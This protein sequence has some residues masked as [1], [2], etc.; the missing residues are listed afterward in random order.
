MHTAFKHPDC[1]LVIYTDLDGTLL[2]HDSYAFAPALPALQRLATLNVPVIPVTSKTLAELRVLGRELNLHGPCI[3]ENGGV[4]AVPEGYFGDDSPLPTQEGYHLEYLSPHYETIVGHL[5]GLRKR[6]GFRFNGFADLSTDA[7]A[8]RTGLGT[9]EAQRARQ[10]LCSEPLAWDDSDTAFEQFTTELNALGYTLVRGG[11]FYHVLGQ[12]DK[13]RAISKLNAMF[14]RA[15]F[16]GYTSL[17]LGDS[18]NDSQM[19]LTAD[20]AVAVRRKD[21]SWLDLDTDKA[22]IQTSATGPDGWNEAIQHYLD[23]SVAQRAAE[24]TQHG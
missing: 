8:E 16:T 13:A 4:I 1:P 6:F 5:N 22:I 7:V 20:V 15:G 12:T 17:A 23:S 3:V 24:R 9:E 18:P 10:R 11:R 14:A 2:D 21:G 19:L